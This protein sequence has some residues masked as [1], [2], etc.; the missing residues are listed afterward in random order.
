[1]T[2]KALEPHRC[3]ISQMPTMGIAYRFR[4]SAYKIIRSMCVERKCTAS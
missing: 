3:C 1:M 4:E 2:L